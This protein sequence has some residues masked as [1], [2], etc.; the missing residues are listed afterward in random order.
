M[1]SAPASLATLAGMPVSRLMPG[2]LGD[3]LIALVRQIADKELRPRV[4][5]AEAAAARGG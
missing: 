1:R 3:D 4:D 2:A 5:E